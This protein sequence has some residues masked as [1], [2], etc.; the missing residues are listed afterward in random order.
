M[1]IINLTPAQQS[2]VASLQEAFTAAQTA[3]KPYHEALSRACHALTVYLNTTAGVPST[4]PH[5]P[6][7]SGVK[8]NEDGTALVVMP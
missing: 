6:G 4:M 2:E 5:R 7:R 3:A 1:R 8:L